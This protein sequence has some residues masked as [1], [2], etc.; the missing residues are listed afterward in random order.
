MGMPEKGCIVPE[1]VTNFLAHSAC[2]A[3]NIISP[4][5]MELEKITGRKCASVSD[6]VAACRWCLETSPQL[7]LCFVKHLSYAGMDKGSSFE[8]LMVT[9]DDCYHISTPLLVSTLALKH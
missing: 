3:A 4:N 8:M 9:N 2:T 7:Q 5:I 1:D 6:A